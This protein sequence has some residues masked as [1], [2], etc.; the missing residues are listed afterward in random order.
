MKSVRPLAWVRLIL[1]GSS[2]VPEYYSWGGR[3][4]VIVEALVDE[5]CE[6]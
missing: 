6:R 1:P 3:F 2:L 4:S 5:M